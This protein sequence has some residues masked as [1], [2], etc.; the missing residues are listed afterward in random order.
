MPTW[1]CKVRHLIRRAFEFQDKLLRSAGSLSAGP[2][3][4]EMGFNGC[5][6]RTLR[7]F[8]Q[9]TRRAFQCKDGLVMGAGSLPAGPLSAN[10]GLSRSA[11]SLQAGP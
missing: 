7:A 4:A 11:D 1:A 8:R 9:L 6:Q 2:L 3:S 10:M 5:G